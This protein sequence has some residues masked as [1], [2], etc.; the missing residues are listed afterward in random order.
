MAC[1]KQCTWSSLLKSIK[2]YLVNFSN[3]TAYFL[4]HQI[5]MSVIRN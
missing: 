2:G 5:A 3:T 1:L 4:V